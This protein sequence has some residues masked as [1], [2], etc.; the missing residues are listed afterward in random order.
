MLLFAFVGGASAGPQLLTPPR[1]VA[2]PAQTPAPS[3]EETKDP[4][5]VFTPQ[6]MK[7]FVAATLK[8]DALKDPMK[9]CLNFPDPPGSHWSRDGVAAYCRFTLQPTVS[10][11]E[12]DRLVRSG[13]AKEL[14]QRLSSWEADPNGHPQAFWYFLLTNFPNGDAIRQALVESWKQ[15]SPNSAFAYA[16]SGWNYTHLGWAARG[17][18]SAADTPQ[19]NFDGMDNS[20]E[21]ARGDV[22]KAIRLN[23]NLSVPYA[24]MITIGTATGDQ[25]YALQGAKQGLQIETTKYAV[26]SRL[27]IYTSSRW[28]GTP[29]AR[30]WLL[31]QVDQSVSKQP[32]LHVIPAIV[33][34][35][36]ALI[37]HTDPIDGDWTV[38]RRVFDDVAKPSLLEAAGQ[39]AERYRQ[40]AVAYVYLS[41][42]ARFDAGNQQVAKSRAHAYSF[43]DLGGEGQ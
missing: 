11:A 20:M 33:F 4:F 13:H 31:S 12:F 2:P 10:L 25:D 26:L 42:A 8:A 39:T 34:A 9:R 3:T 32:L 21:R 27:A 5:A 38:Y 29:E 15:Q 18:A 17:D 41:E 22:E 7:A 19:E 6:E 35:Y 23:P 24:T 16:T 37:D 1:V 43:V 28:H 30:Q 14:D 40:F 36:E